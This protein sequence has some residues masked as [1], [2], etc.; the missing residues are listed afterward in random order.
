MLVRQTWQPFWMK[1]QEREGEQVRQRQRGLGS[2][3]MSPWEYR[4]HGIPPR[5]LLR[6]HIAYGNSKGEA[7]IDLFA[8][9]RRR[10]FGCS[11]LHQLQMDRWSESPPAHQALGQLGLGNSIRNADTKWGLVARIGFSHHAVCAV[12][13]SE[14]LARFL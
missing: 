10:Q 1:Q 2:Q 6:D 5:N 9:Q 4:H 8:L 7:G 12:N 13:A 3:L 14:N 11:H